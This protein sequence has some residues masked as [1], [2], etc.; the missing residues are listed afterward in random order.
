MGGMVADIPI[1]AK[2]Q[3]LPSGKPK[4]LTPEL[5]YKESLAKIKLLQNKKNYR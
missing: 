3:M 5:A 1:L 2:L 4:C